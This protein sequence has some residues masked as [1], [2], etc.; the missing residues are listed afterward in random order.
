MVPPNILVSDD[1]PPIC[2][3][4]KLVLQ[5]EGYNV[6]IASDG[7]EALEIVKKTPIDV[8][9]L[10]I[11]MPRLNGIEALKEIKT[12]DPSIEVIII[13]GFA[14]FESLRKSMVE[15]GAFDYLLKPF[16]GPDITA[17]LKK[18]VLKR[19]SVQKKE[20]GDKIFQ[21]ERDFLERTHE[22]RESQI[23]H[24]EIIENSNDMILVV[25]GG[26][27]K[28]ANRK[29]FELTEYPEKEILGLLFMELINPADRMLV[30]EKRLNPLKSKKSS[31]TYSF[32]TI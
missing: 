14:D 7:I 32:R 28:F 19:D 8:A 22:L 6:F 3:L 9:I 16:K 12:I 29:T 13:T 10:D 26:R 31:T 2:E 11:R 27:I 15:Y 24:K 4:L 5:G 30:K 23:K 25:Q 20:P 17:I 1:E 21:L 18:A